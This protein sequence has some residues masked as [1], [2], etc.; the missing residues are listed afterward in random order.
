MEEKNKRDTSTWAQHQQVKC[1][2][3]DLKLQRNNLERHI[4]SKHRDLHE[5]ALEKERRKQPKLL[6][7]L[8]KVPST[9]GHSESSQQKSF[10]TKPLRSSFDELQHTSYSPNP[11]TSS[12]GD[13]ECSQHLPPQL[14]GTLRAITVQTVRE[15][16]LPSL[17][18]ILENTAV[19]NVANGVVKKLLKEQEK[20][21][22]ESRQTHLMR[23]PHVPTSPA[24]SSRS[25]PHT[26][27]AS[28]VTASQLGNTPSKL[29][30]TEPISGPADLNVREALGKLRD[31]A[32]TDGKVLLPQLD[33]SCTQREQLHARLYTPRDRFLAMDSRP[34]RG[35]RSLE[36][37]QKK[38]KGTDIT[39][40][41]FTEPAFYEG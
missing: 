24:G 2:H 20:Q 31:W 3:C 35:K 18:T 10:G 13:V 7:T 37:Q 17:N 36:L 21:R 16:V 34:Q 23:D 32:C 26:G 40:V 15:L 14:L 25:G 6:D 33:V 41:V 4:Q 9:G 19:D 12:Q 1:P 5:A 27:Q 8:F 38:F 29:P 39:K 11:G 22:T 30:D 28:P